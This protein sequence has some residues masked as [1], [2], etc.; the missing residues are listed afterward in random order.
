MSLRH[1]AADVR[2][3]GRRGSFP[4]AV[5]SSLLPHERS[6]GPSATSCAEVAPGSSIPTPRGTPVASS[7]LAR[8]VLDGFG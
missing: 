4:S 3:L 1:L 5:Q 2:F 8:S 7:A 6:R